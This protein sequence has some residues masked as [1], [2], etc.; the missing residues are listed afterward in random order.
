MN[1]K[2][3]MINDLHQDFIANVIEKVKEVVD[4]AEY[5]TQSLHHSAYTSGNSHTDITLI[6]KCWVT[7]NENVA[8]VIKLAFPHNTSKVIKVTE[9]DDYNSSSAWTVKYKAKYYL[10]A[11][12]IATFIGRVNRDEVKI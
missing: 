9:D 11:T 3:E 7:G 8:K 10:M 12:D 1:R 2:Q 5:F 6:I 4:Q